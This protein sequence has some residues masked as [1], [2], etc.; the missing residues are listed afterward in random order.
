MFLG[1]FL[2]DRRTVTTTTSMD[3]EQGTAVWLDDGVS[4]P[5]PVFAFRGRDA[6]VEFKTK[7]RKCISAT[8]EHHVP[9]Y[10]PGC[11]STQTHTNTQEEA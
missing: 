7:H 9:D 4:F 3:V 11:A 8:T 2:E 5:K 10:G 6:G 1:V